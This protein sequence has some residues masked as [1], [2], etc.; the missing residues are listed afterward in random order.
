MTRITHIARIGL[1][2]GLIALMPALAQAECYVSYKAKREDPL[3]LHFGVAAVPDAACSKDAA[4]AALAPRLAHDGWILLTIAAMID[5]TE[6]EALKD[7]VGAFFLK[8]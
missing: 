3:K 8:Y 2:T 1:A 4:A 5:E 6:L 7:S